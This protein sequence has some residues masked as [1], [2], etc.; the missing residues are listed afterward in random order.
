MTHLMVN[1]VYA[2]AIN[3]GSFL[4]CD[5]TVRALLPSDGYKLCTGVISPKPG[6][7]ISVH[8]AR[9]NMRVRAVCLYFSACKELQQET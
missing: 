7:V 5:R 8:F 6:P 4:S 9:E 2:D 1:R 3:L